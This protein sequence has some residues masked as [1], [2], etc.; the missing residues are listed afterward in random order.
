[1]GY[2]VTIKEPLVE[3]SSRENENEAAVRA[4]WA[5]SRDGGTDEALALLEPDAEWRLHIYPDRVLSTAEFAET[6]HRIERDRRVTSAH[7][8]HLE[9]QGDIVLAS[10]SFRWTGDDGGI[11]DFRGYWVYECVGGRIVR[12]QS[13]AD[14]SEAVTAFT[15]QIAART[16]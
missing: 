5:A 13:F 9:A 11:S 14:W 2:D 8:H 10:G 12:G 7:L 3:G 6:L 4:L 16:L 1:M 15:S